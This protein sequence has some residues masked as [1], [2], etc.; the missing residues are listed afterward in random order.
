M[1]A[2]SSRPPVTQHIYPGYGASLLVRARR[3][4]ERSLRQVK[5]LERGMST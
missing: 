1:C 5:Q 4:G 3:L 2:F